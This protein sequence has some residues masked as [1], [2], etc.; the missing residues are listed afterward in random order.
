[1]S[2]NL[3]RGWFALRDYCGG[4]QL[5]VSFHAKPPMLML[6]LGPW[7]FVVARDAPRHAMGVITSID[8]AGR[9]IFIGDA[10]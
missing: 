6:Y 5:G 10:E 4:F 3:F 2:V 1:M 9:R 8:Y 7:C